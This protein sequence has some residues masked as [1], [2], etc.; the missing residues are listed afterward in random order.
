MTGVGVSVHEQV[1]TAFAPY[2]QIR[3]IGV[4]ITAGNTWRA[5]GNWT[6]NVGKP[7]IISALAEAL[8]GERVIFCKRRNGEPME[9]KRVLEREL[10]DFKV[11]VTKTGQT[12]AEAFNSDHDDAVIALS[13]PLWVGTQNWCEMDTLVDTEDVLLRQ[14]ERESID[15][16]QAIIADDEAEALAL[17]QGILT[18]RQQA[19]RELFLQ[20]PKDPSLWS[21]PTA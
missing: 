9:N 18:P 8:G 1:R 21:R 14:Q 11:K 15:A 12:T 6:F 20:N 2:P 19:R 13:L 4:S 3:V 16:E 7:L 10:A 17:E 5:T